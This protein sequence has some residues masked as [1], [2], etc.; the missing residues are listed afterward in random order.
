M[1][2][3]EGDSLRERKTVPLVI[4]DG[5][6]RVVNAV[7]IVVFSVMAPAFW[8]LGWGWFG[9]VGGVGG[10]IA[11]RCVGGQKGVKWDRG[12]F[13]WWCGW[14]VGLYLLPLGKVVW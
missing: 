1:E 10:G 9:G 12:T 13:K 8:G 3:Q 5:N 4:G 2:D 7:V 6:A 11:W 14:L